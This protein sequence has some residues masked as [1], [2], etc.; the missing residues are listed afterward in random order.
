ML[1]NLYDIVIDDILA[2]RNAESIVVPKFAGNFGHP[3]GMRVG[4][5]AIL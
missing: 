3:V 5:G 4:G 2:L 1:S